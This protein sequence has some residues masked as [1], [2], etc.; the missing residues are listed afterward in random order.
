MR[1][2][3]KKLFLLFSILHTELNYKLSKINHMEDEARSKYKASL[4]NTHSDNVVVSI[5]QGSRKGFL[6]QYAQCTFA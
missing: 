3:N 4:E 2:D 5:R 6:P 1:N